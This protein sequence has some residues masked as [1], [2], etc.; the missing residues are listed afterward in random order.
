MKGTENM[1]V[2]G[3]ELDASVMDAEEYI[4]VM[5]VE[6]DKN[7]YMAQIPEGLDNLMEIVGGELEITILEEK[8]IAIISD[9]DA[10]DKGREPNRM[11]FDKEGEPYDIICGN[12]MIAGVDNEHLTSLSME[13]AEECYKEFYGPMFFGISED[14][15]I[16]DMEHEHGLTEELCDREMD[17]N[18]EREFWD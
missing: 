15:G 7:P 12:F 6:A 16:A 2:D 13:Q 8:D 1:S 5:I 3:V 10:Y 9:K 11:L 17:W 14:R 18:D 4:D